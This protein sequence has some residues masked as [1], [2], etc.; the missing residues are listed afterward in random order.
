MRRIITLLVG[1][2]YLSTNLNAQDLDYENN[3]KWFWGLNAGGTWHTTDVQNKSGFGLGLTFGRSL[4]YDYGRK[5]SFDIRGRMLYGEWIGQD[6]KRT[7]FFTEDDVLSTGETNYKDSLGYVF[8]NFSDQVGRLSLEFVMHFNAIRERTKIDPYIFAGIGYSW[9]RAEG[10][11]INTNPENSNDEGM[12]DYA[13]WEDRLT[14]KEY[15]ALQDGK[16]ETFLNGSSKGKKNV[17][18][19]PSVGFGIGYQ[20]APRFSMGFEHKTTF[21]GIDDFDGVVNQ[22]GAIKNDWYHYSSIYL[23]FY[24][25]A[26][27][28]HRTNNNTNSNGF[29][30][31]Q[32]DTQP[33][34][35]QFTNPSGSRTNTEIVNYPIRAEIKNVYSAE[36]VAFTQNGRS[37]KNFSFNPSSRKFESNVT[38]IEGENTFELSGS[39]VYGTDSKTTIIIYKKPDP[40]PPV[41]SFQNPSTTPQTVSSNEFNLEATI[42]NVDQKSQVRLEVNGN[43]QNNFSFNTT[44]KKLRQNISLNVGINTVQI[45][46]TNEVGVD[47]KTVAIIYNPV[48]TNPNVIRQ[49]PVVYFVTPSRSPYTSNITTMTL[50][51]KV[52]YVANKQNVTF[53]QNGQYNS[54][55]SF[56]PSTQDF[57]SNVSL[58]AG[59]N[60]FEIIGT[61]QDGSAQ[62][63]TIVIYERA[64]YNP[65]VVTFTNPT[66]NPYYTDKDDF[67]FT[68][69]IS[70]VISKLQVE[71]R[72]NG[73]VT[74]NFTYNNSV[75]KSNFRLGNG[76]T[77]IEVKGTN[78]DGV[79]QKLTTVVY[80]KPTQANRNPPVVTIVSP[81]VNP[82]SS[83]QEDLNF[84]ATVLNVTSKSQVEVKINGQI[85]SDFTYSNSFVQANIRLGSGTTTIEVKGTNQDGVD[86]KTTTVNYRKPI[87][88]TPKPPVVT[89]TYPTASPFASREDNLNFSATV[90]NV[91][92]KSQVELKVN[93]QVTTNFTFINATVQANIPLAN[94]TT[95]IEVKGTNQD[96]MDQKE[97]LVTYR[98]PTIQTPTPVI[99]FTNPARC[100]ASFNEGA[101]TVKG[102]ISNVNA[103][104]VIFKLN[105]KV[106]TNVKTEMSGGK[107]V[108]S[109]PVTI[110][111][112]TGD[113][114]VQVEATNSGGSDVKSC[115]IKP[116]ATIVKPTTTKPKVVEPVTPKIVVPKGVK[117]TTKP[118]IIKPDSTIKA[119][120]PGRS[121]GTRTPKP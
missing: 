45:V 96:G 99:V 70:N 9:Y 94:G 12:Y 38:L 31:G 111:V 66:A 8:R 36:N 120:A 52:L 79:D 51:A 121:G 117:P 90:L 1:I 34:V 41:V 22:T 85:I 64:S 13:S 71:V 21:T 23:R 119:P 103:S 61:N 108:F 11:Y 29:S 98:K 104:E 54:N 39:N 17:E 112:R 20:F 107:L 113:L 10:N 50:D 18:L 115:T 75:V 118:V 109:L 114:I 73:Q 76:T 4:N 16:H 30:Q 88:Y 80:R 57:R 53:K 110:Y 78:Q 102:N 81:S 49:I 65:P 28:K 74:P 68:A 55:F 83:T 58:N 7:N 14:N 59:Q 91:S 6:R 72:I 37:I 46:G 100:P 84:S 33:P 24:V 95:R 5:V 77:T 92:S 60:V 97:A 82:Y 69:T 3:S 2:L 25:K 27:K 101:N 116:I 44:T 47:S 105:G 62:A 42:L 67:S 26:S 106:V 63:T 43:Q 35:V 19:M 56:N 93:G 89:I 40:V 32:N 48:Y 15:L 87:A 86:Q